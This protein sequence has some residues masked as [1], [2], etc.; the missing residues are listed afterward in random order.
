ME[1]IKKYQEIITSTLRSYAT[2]NDPEMEDQ[3]LFDYANNHFQLV[4]VGWN[5][6]KFV[7]LPLF[8]VDIKQDG[9][10]W[11]MVNNTDVRVAEELVKKGRKSIFFFCI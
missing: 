6:G 10:I 1:K 3:C 11:L 4:T 8:H 2:T 5:A 7:F 9:K